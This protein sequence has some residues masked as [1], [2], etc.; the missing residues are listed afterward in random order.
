MEAVHGL[1]LASLP[2]NSNA[3]VWA[4]KFELVNVIV[5]ETDWRASDCGV[6]KKEVIC[7]L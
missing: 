7:E 3:T 4:E 5:T 6:P 1:P 2:L